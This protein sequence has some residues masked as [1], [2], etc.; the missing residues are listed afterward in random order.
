M[1]R[2]TPSFT[3][4]P[5]GTLAGGL[6]LLVASA[7]VGCA[8]SPSSLCEHVIA[9]S[10]GPPQNKDVR[11]TEI[12]KCAETWTQKRQQDPKAYECYVS[13]AMGTKRLV[14]IG[15]CMPKCYPNAPKPK[16]EVDKLEG[17][18]WTGPKP[19]ESA[20]ASASAAPSA[21]ASVVP[22]ASAPSAKASAAKKAG[23]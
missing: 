23:P 8:T 3:D 13:C 22:S 21:S 12:A 2:R 16:D 10:D 11:A 9:V 20:S 7:L 19:G 1:S 4:S 17:I 14:E 18:I 15:A 6:A 5:A